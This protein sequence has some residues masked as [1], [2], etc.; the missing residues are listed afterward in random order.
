MVVVGRD[1]ERGRAAVREIRHRAPGAE[2]DL[3]TAD[4]SSLA[5]VRRLAAEV[6]EKYHRLDVLDNNAGVICRAAAAGYGGDSYAR[7]AQLLADADHA[8]ASA[9]LAM[10]EP[11]QPHPSRRSADN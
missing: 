2:V 3:L 9:E 7:L 4:M 1:A 11:S 10:P 8:N 6:L 5:E